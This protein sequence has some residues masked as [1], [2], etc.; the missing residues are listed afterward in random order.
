MVVIIIITTM[1][2]MELEE[3]TKGTVVRLRVEVAGFLFCVLVSDCQR[4]RRQKLCACAACGPGV[5]APMSPCTAAQGHRPQILD[6]KIFRR[7]VEKR[8]E[9]RETEVK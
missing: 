5:S 4:F 9:E 6:A 2:M 1:W 3:C 8:E 7:K